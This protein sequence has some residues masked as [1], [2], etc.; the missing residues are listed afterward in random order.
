V[1]FTFEHLTTKKC[2]VSV[3]FTFEHLTTEKGPVSVCLTQKLKIPDR[4]CLTFWNY[5]T[6][7]KLKIPDRVCL[8]FWNYLTVCVSHVQSCTVMCWRVH[9]M[10]WRVHDMCWRV[11]DMCWRVHDVY[12]SL[13]DLYRS[14]LTCTTIWQSNLS[15][16]TFFLLQNVITA[17]VHDVYMTCKW[18][19]HDVKWHVHHV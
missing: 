13:I 6:V 8:T 14:D 15:C 19:V 1:C 18:R 5:L 7:T 12:D 17:R 16:S 10:C 9:D 2:P 3:C 11:H 4:V